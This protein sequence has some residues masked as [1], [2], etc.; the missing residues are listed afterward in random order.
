MGSSTRL[1]RNRRSP[2]WKAGSML[3]LKSYTYGCMSG[4]GR[5]QDKLYSQHQCLPEHDNNRTFTAC[6][7]HQSFPDHQCWGHYHTKVQ[8]LVIELKKTTTQLVMFQS[9]RATHHFNQVLIIAQTSTT[10]SSLDAFIPV[11][12]NVDEKLNHVCYYKAGTKGYTWP[13]VNTEVAC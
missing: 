8:H 13:D 1:V 9:W 12:V 7:N 10:S 4:K 2:R 11:S 6:H 5:P 3:P